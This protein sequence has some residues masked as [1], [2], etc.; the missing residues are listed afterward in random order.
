MSSMSATVQCTH[1]LALALVAKPDKYLHDFKE[2]VYV[3]YI[4]I[5]LLLEDM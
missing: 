1:F 4:V 3:T 2:H 5:Y